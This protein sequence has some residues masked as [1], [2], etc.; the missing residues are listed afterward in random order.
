MVTHISD[1]SSLGE[2]TERGF[3][4]GKMERSMMV[5]GIKASSKV[6]VYGKVFTT[7][8]ILESGYSQKPMDMVFINGRMVIDMKASGKC[9]SS[10]ARVQTVLPMVMSTQESMLMESQKV[11]V[12]MFGPLDKSTLATFSK[13]K[14]MAK[15]NGEVQETIR[16]SIY[17]MVTFIMTE[18]MA[19]AYSPG[20]VETFIKEIMLMTSARVTDK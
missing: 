17:M 16:V 5:S 20:L 14:S 2:L 12:N 11:K 8:H 10:M 7:I 6:M 13:A 1:S 4:L 18:S 9:V 19:K 3:I 15:V